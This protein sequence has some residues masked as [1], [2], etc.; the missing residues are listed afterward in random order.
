M[1]LSLQIFTSINQIEARNG[2]RQSVCCFIALSVFSLVQSFFSNFR[3]VRGWNLVGIP[4]YLEI[5]LVDAVFYLL[6]VHERVSPIALERTWPSTVI[7]LRKRTS[8]QA[9][10][11]W[12]ETYNIVLFTFTFPRLLLG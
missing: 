6:C 8:P 3:V 10:N 2:R 1:N 5:A 7:Q 4:W 11:L 9:S 12:N